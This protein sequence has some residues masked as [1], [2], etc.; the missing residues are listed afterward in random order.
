MKELGLYA[1]TASGIER[2]MLNFIDSFGVPKTKIVCH[3][4]LVCFYQQ[5]ERKNVWA[6]TLKD[7]ERKSYHLFLYV[8]KNVM[9]IKVG[10]FKF[11]PIPTGTTLDSGVVGI[12]YGQDGEA[13]QVL[14]R[15][16]RKKASP[17]LKN[18]YYGLEADS[19]EYLEKA[20][21]G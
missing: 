2:E 15:N 20:V 13:E 12:H 8:D 14:Y 1:E 7:K 19:E 17:R 5:G 3:P 9:T 18:D 21:E 10:T 4:R 11:Y 16:R 6:M